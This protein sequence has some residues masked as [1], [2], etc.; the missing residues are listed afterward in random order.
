MNPEPPEIFDQ[1]FATSLHPQSFSSRLS[2]PSEDSSLS[3]EP[4]ELLWVGVLQQAIEDATAPE[5]SLSPTADKATRSAYSAVEVARRQARAFL[6]SHSVTSR[7]HLAD[8]CDIVKIDP[9]Y[10]KEKVAHMIRNHISFRRP[11]DPH[12]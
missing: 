2:D 7:A 6:F 11:G 9:D 8:I 5:T 1:E 10:L 12:E 4:H 3:L